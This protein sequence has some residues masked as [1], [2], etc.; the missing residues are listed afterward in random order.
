MKYAV[1]A[2]GLSIAVA[3]SPQE[4][5]GDR[6]PEAVCEYVRDAVNAVDASLGNVWGVKEVSYDPKSG[7]VYA[8]GDVNGRGAF[9]HTSVH[10]GQVIAGN[11]KGEKWSAE[12][13]IM[14]YSMFIDPPLGRVGLSEKQAARKPGRYLLGTMPM[15]S[16]NRAV[17]KDETDGLVKVI[18][19]AESGKIAEATVF[20]VGG[21]EV[22]SMLAA[23]M[24]TGRPYTELQRAVFVHP[25]VSELMPWVFND[26]KAL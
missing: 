9:T 16:I 5:T 26:L 7:A 19:E 6:T 18:V 12:D 22:I 24:Y 11:L 1:A 13:R 21:D 8:V 14:I 15:S 20:G 23:W 25:T 3:C 17:E 2:L 4:Y 10:D